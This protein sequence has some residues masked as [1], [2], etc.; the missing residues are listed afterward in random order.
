M[1]LVYI[2]AI[3]WPEIHIWQIIITCNIATKL[4]SSLQFGLTQICDKLVKVTNL[5]IRRNQMFSVIYILWNILC[6]GEI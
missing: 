1:L 6:L 3:S 2:F 4:N 5:F